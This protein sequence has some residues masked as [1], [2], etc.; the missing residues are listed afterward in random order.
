MH[1]EQRVLGEE[2]KSCNENKQSRLDG[3]SEAQD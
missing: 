2:E 3:C 1:L